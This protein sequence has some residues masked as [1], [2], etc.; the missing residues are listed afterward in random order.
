MSITCVSDFIHSV[1]QYRNVIYDI[2]RK[3]NASSQAHE[4]GGGDAAF[5]ALE[6]YVWMEVWMDGWMYG[7]MYGWM[8][9]WMDGCMH[10][11]M[12]V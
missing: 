5:A 12:D 11:W 9:G 8:H 7:N 6:K 2:D 4:R 10:G 1:G 3:R